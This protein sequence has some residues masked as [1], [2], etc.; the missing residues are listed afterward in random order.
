MS[1]GM[2]KR[3]MNPI[4]MLFFVAIIIL[5]LVIALLAKVYVFSE[6]RWSL[7]FFV[8]IWAGLGSIGAWLIG[9]FI[10]KGGR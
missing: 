2:R 8:L 9:R 7:L 5:S 10:N 6:S 4:A 3:G 1:R